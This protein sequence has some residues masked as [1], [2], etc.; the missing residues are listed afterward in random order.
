[1]TVQQ[2]VAV[3][4]GGGQGLGRSFCLALAEAGWAVAV[5]DLD[6]E[7]A[8]A[9]AGKVEAS[10]GIAKGFHADV[11]DENA[12]SRLAEQI[13]G[14]LGA[15]SVLVN[16]A[17]IFSTLSM[18]SYDEI[19]LQTWKR[20]MDVNVTGTFLCCKEFAPRMAAAGYGKI[21]NISS[22]TVFTGRPGYLHYV[23]SK[24]AVIGLTRALASEVGPQGV[25]VNAL[26]P[27]S[28]ETE[29][30]R[31]TITR[32]AREKMAGETALRRVQVAEDLVGT[33]VFLASEASDFVTGQTINVD[34]GLAF[35]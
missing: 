24:A 11:S 34:G 1:M 10:G 9:I 19:S 33:V 25:R 27:G 31:A 3:V 32:E 35:H 17:A 7:N 21:V 6:L 15:V 26:A 5:V 8:R 23:T 14:G 18:G 30:E 4:T 2:R 29:V 28:T 13:E 16:N 20:V 22:A 12:V